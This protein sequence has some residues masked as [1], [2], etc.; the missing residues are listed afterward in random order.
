MYLM[1]TYLSAQSVVLLRDG[2]QLLAEFVGEVRLLFVGN[3]V[4]RLHHVLHIRLQLDH[5]LVELLGEARTRVQ[6]SVN[7]A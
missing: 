6:R 7:P 3:L 4:P 5:R 2:V 1:V